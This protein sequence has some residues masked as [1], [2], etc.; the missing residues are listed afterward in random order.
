MTTVGN[1]GL[2]TEHNVYTWMDEIYSGHFSRF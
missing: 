1:D 2:L